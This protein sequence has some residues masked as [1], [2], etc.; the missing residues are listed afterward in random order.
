MKDNHI[1]SCRINDHLLSEI[2]WTAHSLH[3]PQ[4]SILKLSLTDSL[5]EYRPIQ[6]SQTERIALNKNRQQALDKLGRLCTTAS[7]LSSSWLHTG[8]NINQLARFANSNRQLPADNNLV[9]ASSDVSKLLQQNED[10]IK[11][12]K[13]L[14]Q[15]LE[16]PT[17]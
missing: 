3:R 4:S 14:W 5:R 13:V 1:I 15:L 9:K 17:R 8:N 7:Q 10:L 2:K 16:L 6:L 11:E 12:L